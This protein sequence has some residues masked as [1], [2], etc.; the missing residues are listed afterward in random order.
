MALVMTGHVML[1]PLFARRFESFGAGVQALGI[2]DA[3]AAL[4]ATIA[5]PF[6]GMLADR[7]GRRPILLVSLAGT[8]LAFG[9]F[10]FAA[11]TGLLIL[12]RGVAG[13][14]SAGLLP[15][16]VSMVGDLAQENRRAQGIG[17]VSGG[18]GA[19]WVAGPV[20][21]G[22]LYDRFGYVVPFAAAIGMAAAALVVAALLVPEAYTPA[23]P[24]GPRH[25]AGRL[26]WGALPGGSSVVLVLLITFG[27]MLA[28][29]FIGPQ[30]MFYAYDDLGWTSAQMG[31]I[32]STYGVAFM[33][34]QLGLGRLSDRVGR[35]PVVVL[36]LALFSAQFAGLLLFREVA[37]IVA[38]FIVAGLGNALYDPALSAI[39]L[40]S[41]PRALT[42]RMMGLKATAASLGNLLGPTLVVL[43]APLAGP[44]VV[45]LISAVLVA[46]LVVV[47]ATGLQPAQRSQAPHQVSGAAVER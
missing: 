4:A 3:V 29:T 34:G 42:A 22:L 41:T 16:A 47:A 19:G 9:G 24:A 13:V 11:S 20:L 43:I 27:V 15:A 6:I 30:L 38:S 1:M 26:R 45:F 23:T 31:L 8:V 32:M 25:A 46:L 10:L 37:W 33:I 7:F 44:Q 12:L 36:G 14:F 35:R 2:S 17:L 28:W 40:D 18:A 21:G 39:I 5:A